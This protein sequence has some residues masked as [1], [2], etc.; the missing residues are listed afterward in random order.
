MNVEAVDAIIR[1]IME[2]MPERTVRFYRN[3]PGMQPSDHSKTIEDIL[4]KLSD[5]EAVSMVSDIVDRTIFALLHLFDLGFKDRHIQVSF[6]RQQ[7]PS[8]APFGT[9][10]DAYRERVDPGGKI[11]D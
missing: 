3:L 6:T 11:I 5:R 8:S 9:L 10:L 4:S 1:D 2:T 7:D